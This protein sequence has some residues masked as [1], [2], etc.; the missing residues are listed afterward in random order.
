MRQVLCSCRSHDCGSHYDSVRGVRGVMV[1]SRVQSRHSLADNAAEIRTRAENAHRSAVAAEEER[2][3]RALQATSL[4]ERAAS[5]ANAARLVTNGITKTISQISRIKDKIQQMQKNVQIIGSAQP[6]ATMDDIC[7]S[8][9]EYSAIRTDLRLQRHQ[10]SILKGGAYRNQPAVKHLGEETQTECDEL[11]KVLNAF[12]HSWKFL[13][14]KCRDDHAAF[15][16]G[17]GTAYDSG[18]YFQ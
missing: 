3:M 1:D 13:E 17:G 4:S 15:L 2:T 18:A 10:L 12:E 5:D 6:T 14:Q 11:K 7:S 8:L 16:Q 9:L